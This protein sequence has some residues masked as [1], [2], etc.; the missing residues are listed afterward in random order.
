VSK[1]IRILIELNN[2]IFL[3]FYN[4]LLIAGF[5]IFNLKV[6]A[7]HQSVFSS[8][9]NYDNVSSHLYPLYIIFLV[10]NLSILFNFFLPIFISRYIILLFLSYLF[11]KGFKTYIQ[12]SKNIYFL[13]ANI[14]TPLIISV[15]TYGAKFHYDAGAYH[16]NFQNWIHQYKIQIG[17]SNLNPY[18]SYGSLQEYI[19]SNFLYLNV[20]ILLFFTELIFFVS[21]LNFLY[22]NLAFS[23]KLFFKYSSLFT[24]IF[25]FLDNFGFMGGGNGS[26]QIQMPGK[27]DTSVGI[28]MYLVTVFILQDLKTN[29]TSS[30]KFFNILLLGLFA[31]QLKSNSVFLVILIGFYIFKFKNKINIFNKS[32][33]FLYFL[34]L[35]FTI[36]NFL[37]SGC[38][39]Y[40]FYLSCVKSV[41]WINIQNIYDSIQITVNDFGT[42]EVGS[43]FIEWLK[44]FISFAYNK[45][46]YSNLLL[47]VIVLL[48]LKIIFF[49]KVGRRNDLLYLHLTYLTISFII[50]FLTVPAFRNAYGLIIS[51]SLL[52]TIN[53]IKPKK[54]AEKFDNKILFMIFFLITALL[55]PRNFMYEEAIN[56]KFMYTDLII[57][58]PEYENYFNNL[59][60]PIENNKCW[61]N[62]DCILLVSNKKYI[63]TKEL[64]F[65]YVVNFSY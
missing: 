38:L 27:P 60:K 28:L 15:A 32:N 49:E 17:L 22:F 54:Y 41:S 26:I 6:F 2:L 19:N 61:I 30:S 1:Y 47:S 56:K 42:Y 24:L 23:K 39:L 9:E 43:N 62:E 20:N 65:N 11:F 25:L 13:S 34:F 8:E 10:G 52:F 21:F 64:K 5:G 45:Q 51:I 4:F 18:Y 46:I 48:V 58:Q 53:E 35:F 7:K 55:L 16:L 57:E 31:Y 63:Y 12:K 59:V 3:T 50:F 33:L 14:I 36:K 44:F 37:I 40:P 29:S